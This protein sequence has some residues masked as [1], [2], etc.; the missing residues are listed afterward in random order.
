M[1]TMMRPLLLA[2]ALLLVPLSSFAG[3]FVSVNIAPPAL[4]VYEQPM[5]PG[6]GYIWT[7][8]YWGWDDDEGDYYW[9][10]G[11][12]VLAPQPGYLWTPGWWGWGDSAFIWHVGYWGPHVGFY[13]GVNYGYGY[14]GDGYQGG[15]WRNGNFFYNRSVNNVNVTNIHN[16]YNETVVNN[17]TVN[18]VSYSGGE[19]GVK[20]APTAEQQ[21]FAAE[22]HVE[23]TSEQTHHI[24]QASSNK[25]L[26][27]AANGGKPAIA[28]TPKP[29]AFAG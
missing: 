6:D 19:G 3:V 28:A 16:T 13:G 17:V 20:A 29:G 5:A 22:R 27:A 4:P 2:L 7:P 15:E 9:V 8:G 24:Q 25:A 18:N 26:F 12:W 14:G 10:P 23:P 21:Q 1:K 11:T